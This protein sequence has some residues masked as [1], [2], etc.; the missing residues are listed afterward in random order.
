[1]V[2]Q[3]EGQQ[4][5]W[6]RPAQNCTDCAGA[7]PQY[8][9]AD[10]KAAGKPTALAVILLS[11]MLHPALIAEM[12]PEAVSCPEKACCRVVEARG[13]SACIQMAEI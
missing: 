6:R 11:T 5:T 10:S 4:T 12:V 8:T 1:M 7:S 2:Q 9:V 3:Q 13:T